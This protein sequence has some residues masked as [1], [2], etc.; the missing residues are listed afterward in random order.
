MI[1]LRSITKAARLLTLVLEVISDESSVLAE[2]TDLERIRNL[3]DGDLATIAAS[4]QPPHMAINQFFAEQELAEAVRKIVAKLLDSVAVE[5]IRFISVE[6]AA[7]VIGM[8]TRAVTKA[9]NDGRL[10]GHKRGLRDWVVDVRSAESYV[11]ATS[12]GR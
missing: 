11:V 7:A 4:D 2:L 10:V 1:D 5:T 3:T 12:G 6:E 9:L 8:S